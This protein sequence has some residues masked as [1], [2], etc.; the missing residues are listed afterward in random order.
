[1]HHYTTESAAVELGE[2]GF[3]VNIIT[4]GLDGE[5]LADDSKTIGVIAEKTEE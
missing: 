2:A 4:G 3:M 1:M 5:P